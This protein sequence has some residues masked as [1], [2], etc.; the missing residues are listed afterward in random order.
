VGRAL[1]ERAERLTFAHRRWLYVSSDSHN[2]TA[3]RFYKRVGFVRAARLPD[4]VCK[5][6]TEILWRKSRD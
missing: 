1:T 2:L 5:A 6:R 3:A 4:L